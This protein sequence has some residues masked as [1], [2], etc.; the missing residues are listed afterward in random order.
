MTCANQERF[1]RLLS[2]RLL[3]S[4][5]S[6]DLKETTKL[7]KIGA[8]VNLAEDNDGFTPLVL[9]IL[10]G[11]IETVK[12]LIASG[13]NV[14][15]INQKQRDPLSQKY[16]RHGVGL[17][18]T[19]LCIAASIE[20]NIEMVK[21][22]IAS[23]GN[24]NQANEDGSTPLHSASNFG[25]LEIVKLLI[26]SGG[27]VNQASNYYHGW[28]PL[29]FASRDGNIEVVKFLIAS[30]A[31]VSQPN[32]YNVT[33]LILAVMAFGNGTE[34]EMEARMEIVSFLIAWGGD[35]GLLRGTPSFMTPLSEVEKGCNTEV[36]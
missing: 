11:H 21:L 31:N 34:L 15:Q 32:D 13:V 7:I 26:A 12:F 4:C 1:Q 14:N 22:L 30:G 20:D 23:G 28:T 18:S 17:G 9:A 10:N 16:G 25:N 8:N 5:I 35:Q 33:P 6:G 3:N 36:I 27:N 2:T 29:H 19:P 24:I